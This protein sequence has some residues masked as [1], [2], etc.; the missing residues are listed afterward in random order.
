MRPTPT[1]IWVS[2]SFSRRNSSISEAWRL[3]AR[4][5]RTP[6]RFSRV[7]FMMR[8]S[9]PWFARYIGAVV[10]MIPNTTMKRITMVT[11]KMRPAR[12]LIVK[13][14]TM[15]PNTMNGERM[16]R[17]SAMLT[18]LSTALMSEVM[19]VIRGLVPSVSISR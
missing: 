13:A 4:T 11:A 18:P 9:W 15:A 2:F 5:T 8:S 10:R 12:A 3:K 7:V 14:M 6:S 1:C 19:R 16:K 17:R